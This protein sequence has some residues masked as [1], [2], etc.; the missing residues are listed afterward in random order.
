[1]EPPRRPKPPKTL[2]CKKGMQTGLRRTEESCKNV[3]ELKGHLRTCKGGL[4]SKPLP[5]DNQ[6]N[7]LSNRGLKWRE[8]LEGFRV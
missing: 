4:R 1:M 7:D 8:G 3:R 5:H 6:L 2:D